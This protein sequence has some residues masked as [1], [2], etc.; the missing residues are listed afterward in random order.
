MFHC[1]AADQGHGI[2][3]LDLDEITSYQTELNAINRDQRERM[4]I[5][6]GVHHLEGCTSVCMYADTGVIEDL[7]D[8]RQFA[9]A[10]SAVSSQTRSLQ[11]G[12]VR[13]VRDLE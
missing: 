13:T 5:H 9:T 6:V 11:Q 10:A 1:V 2:H 3:N 8:T 12:S 4:S 7:I